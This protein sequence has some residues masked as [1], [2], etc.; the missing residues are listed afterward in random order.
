MPGIT[1]YGEV[2]NTL[3]DLFLPE[4]NEIL[5]KYDVSYNDFFEMW[6]TSLFTDLIPIDLMLNLLSSFIQDGWS[7]IFRLSLTILKNLFS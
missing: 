4:L 2:L 5:K 3:L 7:Y 6:V 1:L